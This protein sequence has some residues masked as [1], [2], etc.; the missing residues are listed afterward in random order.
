MFYCVEGRKK[1]E[2]YVFETVN[3]YKDILDNK[4]RES[5]SYKLFNRGY[6]KGYFYVDNN[7]MNTKYPS[8]FDI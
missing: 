8:N 6:S 3:Y 4:P 1:H 5:R 2:N 7:L